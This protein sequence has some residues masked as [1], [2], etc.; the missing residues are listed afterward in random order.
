MYSTPMSVKM[1]HLDSRCKK[2]LLAGVA[3]A[4]SAAA[5][6]FLAELRGF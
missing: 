6:G 1:A 3:A 2:N 5:G 4:D